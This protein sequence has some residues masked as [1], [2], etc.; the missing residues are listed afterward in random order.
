M[1]NGGLIN[2]S[3]FAF[4][5][6]VRG[7]GRFSVNFFIERVDEPVKSIHSGG[8]QCTNPAFWLRPRPWRSTVTV[9]KF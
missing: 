3:W 2:S 6:H 1:E 4:L 8:C 5:V 7:W 9:D